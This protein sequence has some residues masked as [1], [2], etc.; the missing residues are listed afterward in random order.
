MKGLIVKTDESLQLCFHMPKV[1]ISAETIAATAF[2]RLVRTH[3]GYR[4]SF[5][6]Y[7]CIL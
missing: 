6:A 7:L 5:S 1:G 4:H 3:F 2:Q